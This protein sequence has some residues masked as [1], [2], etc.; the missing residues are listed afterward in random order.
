MLDLPDVVP[1]MIGA[2]QTFGQLLHWNP[3]IHSLVTCGAFT[4]EGEFLELPEFDIASLLAVP[5]PTS[6]MLVVI[7]LALLPLRSRR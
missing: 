6:F 7:G 1:G 5:E 3:H 2:I 4:P